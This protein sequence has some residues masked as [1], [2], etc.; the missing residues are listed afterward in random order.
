VE[1]YW[2]KRQVLCNLTEKQ[3]SRVNYGSVEFASKDYDSADNLN[4]IVTD[5]RNSNGSAGG[6]QTKIFIFSN[7]SSK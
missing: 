1:L 2:W 7:E 5:N 6:K 3:N 4:C